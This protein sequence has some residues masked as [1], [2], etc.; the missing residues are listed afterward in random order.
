MYVNMRIIRID[1]DNLVN[2]PGIRTVIWVSRCDQFCKG[3]HN[4]E[5]WNYELGDPLNSK[6][7]QDII[8]YTDKP[9][10]SGITFTGGD[11][12]SEKNITYTILL[13]KD[14]KEKLPNKDIWVWT[15]RSFEDIS[16]IQGIELFD[17]IV[18]G[19]FEIDKKSTSIKFRGSTN[20]RIIDVRAS[21]E[22]G[23]VV[24]VIN[25]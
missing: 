12:L 10:I 11:P 22:E 20:Q 14:I 1:K 13:A 6:H 9:Y 19:R 17:V 3:C 8:E 4:P 25:Y 23:C 7:F 21:L 18:D 16:M 2:G 5:T 24:N 15:G